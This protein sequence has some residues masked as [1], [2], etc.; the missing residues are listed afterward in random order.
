MKRGSPE[1]AESW[2]GLAQEPAGLLHK[3]LNW[4]SWTIPWPMREGIVSEYVGAAG[5]E[6]AG[7]T[8]KRMD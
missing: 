6:S 3:R 8:D 2:S 7:S 5:R 4:S 1:E